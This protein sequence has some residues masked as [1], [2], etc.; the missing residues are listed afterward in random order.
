MI[1]QLKFHLIL[2]QDEE[3]IVNSWNLRK[4]SAAGLDI[5]SSVFGDEMLPMLMPLLQVVHPIYLYTEH[6]QLVTKKCLIAEA[7]VVLAL[8]DFVANSSTELLSY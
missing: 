2:F 7:L 8:I 1:F 3:D 4:C 6:F 5:M